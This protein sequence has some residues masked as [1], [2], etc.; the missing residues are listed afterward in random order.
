MIL[1]SNIGIFISYPVPHFSRFR[2]AIIVACLL[3]VSACSSA[4][5]PSGFLTDYFGFK[6]GP[7]DTVEKYWVPP[8]IVTAEDF[9]A[10]LRG[11]DKVII[12]PIWVSLRKSKSYDGLDPKALSNLVDLFHKEPVTAVRDRYTVVDKPGPGVMRLSMALT[13]IERPN[14]ILA[15]TSTFM[16]IGLGISTASRILTGEHTNVGSASME[17]LALDSQTGKAL[18]AA[19]DRHP[20]SKNPKK[21]LRHS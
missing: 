1:L 11:Y 9:N 13:R 2:P 21:D 20:G 15:A 16:P 10:S 4:S 17:A 3:A 14:R 6:P 12:D 7:K 8:G 19:I 18:F 5:G